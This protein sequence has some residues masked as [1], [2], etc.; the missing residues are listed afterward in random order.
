MLPAVDTTRMHWIR[1]GEVASSWRP[2]IYGRLD[3]PLSER[4]R[5]QA[6]AV[7]GRLEDL[8]LD[9]VVSSGLAR[10][11]Y[12]AAR[13]RDG[14]DLTRRDLPALREIDR[15]RW[16]GL[17][18]DELER[19]APGSYGA[20]LGSRGALAPP[21]GESLDDLLARVLPAAR[22]LAEDHAGGELAVVAHS[23]V[24]RVLAAH[25]LGLDAGGALRLELGHAG[26]AILDWPA[27]GPNSPRGEPRD[28]GVAPVL[29]GWG[30]DAPPTNR[31]PW[32]RGRRR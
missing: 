11:E 14:R 1:H 26:H 12:G 16:A 20:W 4:G 17:T 8:R 32:Y 24:I 3:V 13:L 31:T 10:A 25:A 28:G 15:G 30:L 22:A 19:I 27:T 7:A 29:V 21:G 5:D 9:A 18:F 6:R 23:W 2:R